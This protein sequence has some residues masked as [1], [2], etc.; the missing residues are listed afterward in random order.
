MKTSKPHF[1][2]AGERRSGTTTLYDLLCKHTEIGMLNIS[3][4]DFFIEPE[5]FSKVQPRDSRLGNWEDNH[6]ISDYWELF[7]DHSEPVI[8]QKDADLLW[9]KSSH[10]RLAKFLPDTK[11]I[12]VLRNPVR[13]AESHYFN[14]L[15]KG[16]EKLSFREAIDREEK[17]ELTDWECLHLQ[18]KARGCYA[19]SL[20]EFYKY[21]SK[22]KVKIVIL[23]ELINNYEVEIESICNFLEINQKELIN[24]NPIHSNKEKLLKRRAFA[25]TLPLRKIFDLWERLVEG[26]I[27][28][29][30]KNK[31]KREIFRKYLMSF[32]KYSKRNN[33]SN[34]DNDSVKL[35]LENYYKKY[36]I[37]LET[38][39][40]RP[41]KYW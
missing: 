33:S 31:S 2:I 13:R 14:E 30:T 29:V 34:S 7:S 9:W 4:Y 15:S 3:D 19:K 12:I 6:D 27:V 5:L 16:R 8:G 41:L 25:K 18:Y 28:R 37:E 11:F 10:E 38:L 17:T 21:I 20:T 35:Y 23:E 32:Y 36:N 22:E 39:I 24:L 1:I 26:V 40:K